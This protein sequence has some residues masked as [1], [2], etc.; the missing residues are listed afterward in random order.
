MRPNNS[1]A[2]AVSDRRQCLARESPFVSPA[3]HRTQVAHDC[4]TKNFVIRAPRLSAG[5]PRRLN[6]MSCGSHLEA[7]V[8]VAESLIR[9]RAMPNSHPH[10]QSPELTC[11]TQ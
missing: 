2:Q 5:P 4:I 1:N 6:A 3:F 8:E 9:S 10:M 7:V 11:S